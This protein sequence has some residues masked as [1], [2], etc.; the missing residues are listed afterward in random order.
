VVLVAA[1]ALLTTTASADAA[2]PGWVEKPRSLHLAFH[3]PASNG[4]TMSL[5]TTGHREVTLGLRKG[6]VAVSYKTTGKVSRNRIEA[7]FGALGALS[8]EFNGRP[9]RFRGAFP[10]LPPWLL[11]HPK[12]S[13]RR[14]Q[15]ET[16][17]FHGTIRF[18]GENGFAQIDT[19][20]AR[21]TVR[22]TYRRLCKREPGGGLFVTLLGRASASAAGKPKLDE[23]SI[24]ILSVS[25][26]QG[27]RRVVFTV[28]GI[29]GSSGDPEIDEFIKVFGP[30]AAVKTFERR[31][32]VRI[33]R[34]AV[35]LGDEG[36]LI[37][38]PL[39]RKR[40]TATVAFPKPFEGTAEFEHAP[41]S[42]PTWVGPLLARLPG[43]G[44]VP[45]TGE[46]LK[47]VLCRLP[48]SEDG[49]S[50]SDPCI[51]ELEGIF[52][53]GRQARLLLTQ[54]SGSHSQALADVKLSWSR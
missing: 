36:S 15:Q 27:G 10:G 30:F 40:V 29:S 54:E 2:R 23:L 33:K 22:R 35:V 50:K 49:N 25:G 38:S 7:D 47:T 51:K 45:L 37:A 26:S 34:S 31:D 41:G 53:G 18:A 39:K 6:G 13:G 16:G 3:A 48:L 20:R 17:T 21:G 46:G 44:A 9:T 4:Y 43:A 11:P 1:V 5:E 14:P 19:D 8:V 32:G 42:A 24:D 52:D 28:F 12:C